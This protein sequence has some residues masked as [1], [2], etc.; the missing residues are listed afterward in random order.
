[1]LL[2]FG[3]FQNT[4]FEDKHMEWDKRSQ[5]RHIIW[6]WLQVDQIVQVAPC[7]RTKLKWAAY[8]PHLNRTPDPNNTLYIARK[9]LDLPV[10]MAKRQEGSGVFT[11][12][13]KN[14]S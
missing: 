13:Q 8:H 12:S 11:A 10:K 3:L 4:V 14:C 7:D 2:F 1:V 6:G 9:T 5:A